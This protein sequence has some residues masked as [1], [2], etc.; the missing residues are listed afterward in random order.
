[1]L[2]I[3]KKKKKREGK[4]WREQENQLDNDADLGYLLHKHLHTAGLSHDPTMQQL[5]ALV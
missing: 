4:K 3:D 5:E 1:M 2:R